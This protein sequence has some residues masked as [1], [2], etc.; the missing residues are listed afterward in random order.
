MLYTGLL[1]WHIVEKAGQFHSKSGDRKHK[2]DYLIKYMMIL[3]GNVECSVPV[4]VRLV[5]FP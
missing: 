2:L 5:V 4:K 3:V 1:S